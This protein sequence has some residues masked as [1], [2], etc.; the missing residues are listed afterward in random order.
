[1]RRRRRRR[2]RRW[3]WQRRR[4]A[5]AVYVFQVRLLARS[6]LC[7][8]QTG[9]AHRHTRLFLAAERCRRHRRSTWQERRYSRRTSSAQKAAVAF[10]CLFNCGASSA[11][12]RRSALFDFVQPTPQRHKSRTTR[13]IDDRSRASAGAREK[14]ALVVAV[15]F[16]LSRSTTR[17]SAR[18]PLASLIRS[19]K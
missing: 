12:R 2:R 7:G 19:S 17:T 14:L 5:L 10:L 4:R 15:V 11:P 6:L 16:E 9:D 3:R 13:E 1:M 18:F 8:R